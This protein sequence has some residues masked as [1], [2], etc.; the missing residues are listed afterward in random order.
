[1]GMTTEGKTSQP[2]QSETR[3]HH[4][5][6]LRSNSNS[7]RYK[8]RVR[9]RCSRLQNKK[10]R[11]RHLFSRARS[12]EKRGMWREAS[13]LLES[14]L[15]L[16]PTDAHSYLA[17]A[18]LE[19]RR[20]RGTRI[21]SDRS[22][23]R[24]DNQQTT[25]ER[26]DAR[27]IFQA[28]T[29]HCPASVHLWHSWAM[30]EQ[31]LGEIAKARELL[32][33]ALE[34]DQ[35]NGYVC[36]SYGLLEMQ[37]FQSFAQSEKEESQKHVKRAR[38]F[39][40][41]GL[42]YQPSAALVC[43]LGQLYLTMGHPHS[44][45]ELYSTYIPKMTNGRERIE[46]YLAASSLE[47]TVF[48]DTERASQLLKEAL[49]SGG[50]KGNNAKHHD[51]RAYVALARLG[52]SGGSADDQVVKNRLKEICIKQ[53]QHFKARRRCHNEGAATSSEVFSVKDGRLFNAWAR[54][55]SKANNLKEAHKILKRGMEMYPKDHTLLQAAGNIEE[56]LTGNV[57]AAR[58]LYSASL[59]LVPSAPA[60][61]AFALLELRSLEEKK[62]ANLLSKQPDVSRVRNLIE[63]ALLI[64]P[65]HGPAYNALGNL[66]RRE[67]NY[68]RAKQ[69]YEDGIAANCTDASSV[70][71]GLAKLHLSMGEVED[72][73]RVLQEGL[74]ISRDTAA[75][76]NENA[77][78]AAAYTR[79]SENVAFLAHTLALIYLSN[80]NAVQAKETVKIGLL[81]CRNSPQLH[82]AMGLCESRL[83][84]ANAARLGYERSLTADQSH[85][86]VKFFLL[87]LF[88]L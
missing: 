35:W 55:E 20:E 37:H 15:D 7:K 46:V 52:T 3:K 61:I 73:T 77:A 51:S 69:L 17:L 33:K 67:G 60:L 18:R 62:E 41:R 44:A 57:T 64:D 49:S 8:G 12:L 27:Q 74:A 10:R 14:I 6:P 16:D 39:W 25:A 80:N 11:V 43:S 47:E 66:E 23:P 38:Q 65:K 19:S 26:R 13:Q 22:R 86:Q 84:N 42:T 32:D 36:H 4:R 85:A 56:R 1:M 21:T 88:L 68:D 78:P 5:N 83:G 45:R 72:A 79:R 50:E 71:H 75:N 31:S 82:L 53:Y 54:L 28:G 58:D 24:S 30:H 48:R 63:E 29:T 81:H 70:Y 9:R 76:N 59:H 40:Q 34:L 2:N 87:L